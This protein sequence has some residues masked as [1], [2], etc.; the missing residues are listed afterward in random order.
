MQLK[1]LTS[2]RFVFAMLVV[3]FHGQSFLSHSGVSDH[4]PS[5]I[6]AM[7]SRGNIGVDFFFVLSGF[8]LSYSYQNRLNQPKDC[9]GFWWARFA[10]IYPAYLL[11]FMV[12]LPIAVHWV[13]SG[14]T[15][16]GLVIAVL[17][18]TLT[19]SWVPAAAM[20]WNAPAWS[21]S[22]EAFFYAL[23]PFIFLRLL[24]LPNRSM[25]LLAI[26]AFTIS[27]IGSLFGSYFGA[28]LAQ[29]LNSTLGFKDLSQ[30]GMRD[31]WAVFPI[32]RF[33]EFLFGM[34]I[35]IL[36][37]RTPPLTKLWR[38]MALLT[39][40]VGL[41]TELI[42]IGPYVPGALF[43]NGLLMP[44][45]GLVL[46]GLARSKSIFFNHSVFVALGDASYSVYLLHIPV[47]WWMQYTDSHALHFQTSAPGVFFILYIFTVICASL[48]SLR[49]IEEPARKLI[50]DFF[51]PKRNVLVTRVPNLGDR[52]V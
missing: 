23:F 41:G 28:A 9:V 39:G 5:I 19:Q 50:R 34:A 49:T 40:L 13:V 2:I 14:R 33:P 3:L 4:W 46:F 8:I 51:K 17:Q 7:M 52:T 38:N 36:F 30:G 47:W 37:T 25:I 31:D 44:F 27:Q 45:L 32:F 6:L 42:V 11:A 29:L 10:R 18:L 16:F 21:L 35:G 43:E 24:V 26:F 22:A 15:R 1:P 12:F 20:E 48:L